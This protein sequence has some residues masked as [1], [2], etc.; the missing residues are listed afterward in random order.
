MDKI[1]E[2]SHF[3]IAYKILIIILTSEKGF[4]LVPDLRI[5]VTYLNIR[6]KKLIAYFLAF[7]LLQ[8]CGGLKAA[9]TTDLFSRS[10]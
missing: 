8:T 2:T 3:E 4:S 10:C 9:I 6:K 1:I 7:T 5:P